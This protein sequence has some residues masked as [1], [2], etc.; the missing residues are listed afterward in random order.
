MKFQQIYST[1]MVIAL[2]CFSQQKEYAGGQ[3]EQCNKSNSTALLVKSCPGTAKEWEEAASKKGCKS[4]PNNC[5]SFEYHCVINAWANETLEV[6]APMI[7]IIGNVCAE[8]SFGGSR[9]QRHSDPNC[10]ACPS[11]YKSTEMHQ[12]QE[13]YDLVYKAREK[14]RSSFIAISSTVETTNT[15]VS[16][17][18]TTLI[19]QQMAAQ[20]KESTS[21]LETKILVPISVGIIFL[22]ILV[23]TLIY[24]ILRMRKRTESFSSKKSTPCQNRIED[25]ERSLLKE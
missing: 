4:I 9:I 5:A 2:L 11:S 7:N 16:T 20:H 18:H 6:C 15:P 17:A 21:D 1:T 23:G 12:Y 22:I 25:I 10:T 8:Y 3:K 24:I 13:C 14:S 19:S